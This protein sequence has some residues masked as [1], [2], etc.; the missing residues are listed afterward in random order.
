[1]SEP[2]AIAIAEYTSL[3]RSSSRCSRKLM[4]AIGSSCFV[5]GAWSTVISGIGGLNRRIGM[6]IVPSFG[7]LAEV[8]FLRVRIRSRDLTQ[9]LT[10]QWMDHNR[11]RLFGFGRSKF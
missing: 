1:A 9:A 5:V 7:I 10:L 3:L 8:K 6:M 2:T 4:A 11:L